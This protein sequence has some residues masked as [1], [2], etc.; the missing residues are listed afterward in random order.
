M[1]ERGATDRAAGRKCSHMIHLPK[2]TGSGSSLLGAS[3]R[4]VCMRHRVCLSNRGRPVEPESAM[5]PPDEDH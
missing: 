4:A 1:P 3:A 2:Q 5:R